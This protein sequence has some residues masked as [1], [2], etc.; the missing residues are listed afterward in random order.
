MEEKS[1]LKIWQFIVWNGLEQ[2]WGQFRYFNSNSIPIP[3]PIENFNSNSNSNSFKL[4][5]NSDY[6]LLKFHMDYAITS[7][8][9]LLT[10]IN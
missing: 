10:V 7:N 8:S 1:I 6:R 5:A 9:T 3:V 4:N 2:G